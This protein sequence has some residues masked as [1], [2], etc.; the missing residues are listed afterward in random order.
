MTGMAPDQ[1]WHRWCTPSWGQ[2]LRSIRKGQSDL[3]TIRPSWFGHYNVVTCLNW[4]D[5]Q[6][7]LNEWKG[8]K[9]TDTRKQ[10][11]LDV[12]LTQAIII[13][14]EQ[15]PLHFCVDFTWWAK[16]LITTYMLRR[17]IYKLQVPPR[18]RKEHLA[19]KQMLVIIIPIPI[20]NNTHKFAFN[21]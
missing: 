8:K 18:S 6:V 20:Y 15:C 21:E 14:A 19:R 10:R 2:C 11:S 3:V 7:T 13:I 9:C 17:A 5:R 12:V 16:G 4:P 1:P